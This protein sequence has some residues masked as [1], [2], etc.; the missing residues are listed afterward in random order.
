MCPEERMYLADRQG[1]FLFGLLPWEHAHLGLRRRHR[2]LHGDGVWMRRDIVGQDQYGSLAIAYEIARHSEDEVGVGAVRL[3]QEFI[4]H[5][6][7]DVGPALDQF[8]P[9]PFMLVS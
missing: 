8:G 1:N 3:G 5:V 6:H 7:R 2:S 4:D 9:Q